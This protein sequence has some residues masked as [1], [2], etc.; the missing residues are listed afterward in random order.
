MKL[1][2]EIIIFIKKQNYKGEKTSLQKRQIM[3][4]SIVA[5]LFVMLFGFTYITNV[6]AVTITYDGYVLYSENPIQGATVILYVYIDSEPYLADL[7]I[8]TGAGYYTVSFTSSP[9]IESAWLW[10][11]KSGYQIKFFEVTMT[12]QQVNITLVL[13]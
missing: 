9:T 1:N 7:D 12:S 13:S 2:I 4:T 3:K 10:V 6:Q 8:T 11:S 5:L